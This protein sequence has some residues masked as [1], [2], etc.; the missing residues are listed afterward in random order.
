M[1]FINSRYYL[2]AIASKQGGLLNC[3]LNAKMY[4]TSL[5]GKTSSM[6]KVETQEIEVSSTII[7][8]T[9]VNRFFGL[10]PYF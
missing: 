10:F 3:D 1:T 5:A 6:V 8:E 4:T 9:S 7:P 2:Q